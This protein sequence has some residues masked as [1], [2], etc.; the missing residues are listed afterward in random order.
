MCFYTDGEKLITKLRINLLGKNK[1]KQLEKKMMH[2]FPDK[3][4]RYNFNFIKAWLFFL[5]LMI[6]N[7]FFLYF[8]NTLLI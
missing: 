1:K 3:K 7:N 5:F 6:I 4:I 2:G 8:F